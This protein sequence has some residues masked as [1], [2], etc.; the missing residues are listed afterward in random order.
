MQIRKIT[1]G[2]QL[3]HD[4][5]RETESKDLSTETNQATYKYSVIKI[6]TDLLGSTLGPGR[7]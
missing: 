5:G 7:K 3:F 6:A 4:S 2:C 1:L